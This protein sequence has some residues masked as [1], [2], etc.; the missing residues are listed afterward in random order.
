MKWIKL[1]FV[2]SLG[3]IFIGTTFISVIGAA[4]VLDQVFKTYILKYETCNGGYR[5]MSP[6][7]MIDVDLPEKG[8]VIMECY[9][10]YNNA[11]RGISTGLSMLL[12]AFPIAIISKK[13]LKKATKEAKE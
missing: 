4:Q 3:V 12:I 8:D 10:D 13:G 9:V 6:E 11:K 2:I 5:Q 1:I 7:R